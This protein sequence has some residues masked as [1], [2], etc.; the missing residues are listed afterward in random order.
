MNQNLKLVFLTSTTNIF[1]PIDKEFGYFQP[2]TLL[3]SSHK[4]GLGI[5]DPKSVKNLSQRG[6]KII[7]YRSLIRNTAQMFGN[8]LELRDCISK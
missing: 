3:L 4:Y 1:E 6:K 5:R 2:K 8:F 7:G